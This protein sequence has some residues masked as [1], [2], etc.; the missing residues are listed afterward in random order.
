MG[1]DI[2]DTVDLVLAV[3]NKQYIRPQALHPLEFTR[4]SD[5][6]ALDP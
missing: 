3:I 1:N 6:K 4:N 5:P 2:F